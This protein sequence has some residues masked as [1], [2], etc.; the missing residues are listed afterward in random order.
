MI[1]TEEEI[2]EFFDYGFT[3]KAELSLARAI[4]QSVLN[5]LQDKLKNSDRYEWLVNNSFDREGC[6]QFHITEHSWKP[7]SITKEPI[8]WV[9][10]VRGPS[11]DK[12]IDSAMEKNN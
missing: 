10:R 5:K 3:T 6:T 2:G 4:E 11:I 9:C 1:L 8:Q 7:H 12:A